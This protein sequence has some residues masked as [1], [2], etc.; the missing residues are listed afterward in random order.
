MTHVSDATIETEVDAPEAPALSAHGMLLWIVSGVV[1]AIAFTVYAL[2]VGSAVAPPLDGMAIWIFFL[3]A[4]G[5]EQVNV[6]LRRRGGIALSPGAVV[7]AL[8]LLYFS[9][10]SLVLVIAAAAWITRITRTPARAAMATASALMQAT[11][12]ATVYTVGRVA[13]PFAYRSILALMLAVVAAHAVRVALGFTLAR[14]IGARRDDDGGVD[15]A[16]PTLLA[17]LGWAVVAL[18]LAFAGEASTR[19][20]VLVGLLVLL[21]TGLTWAYVSERYRRRGLELAQGMARAVLGAAQTESALVTMLERAQATFHCRHAEIVLFPVEADEHPMRTTVGPGGEREVMVP[22]ARAELAQ[23]V[24]DASEQKHGSLITGDAVR[25][26]VRGVTDPEQNIALVAPLHGE[27]RVLGTIALVGSDQTDA[28]LEAADVEL[29]EAL[30]NHVGAALEYGQVERSLAQLGELERKLAHQAYH[31]SLTGL[32]NRTLLLDLLERALLRNDAV[33]GDVVVLYVDLDDFKSIND[34]FGHPAG[35]AVL[36]EVGNRIGKCLRGADT[37]ARLGGDEFAVLIDGAPQLRG[38]I[39]VA[40]RVLRSL[41]PP[42]VHEGR[43]HLV[44]GS[45]GIA[46]STPGSSAEALLR[47]ADI[48]MYRAK[49]AGKGRF[50]IFEESMHA[51]I[52]RQMDMR[53]DLARAIQQDELVLH[54][55]PLVELE[56]ARMVGVEALVRWQHPE[57]GMVPPG[58]FIPLAEETGLI[59]ALGSWVIDKACKQAGEWH[60]RFP[61]DP[62]LS[63]NIN[64]SASQFRT[65]E[66]AEELRVALE[67]N[68]VRPSTVTLEITESVFKEGWGRIL[69]VLEELRDLGVRLAIDDFGTGYSSLTRLQEMP[70]EV[71]KIPK[72]FVDDLA[73][74]SGKAT[75]ARTVVRIGDTIGMKTVAEGIETVEKWHQLRHL[76]C[77]YGQGYLFGKP[78]PASDLEAHFERS[79]AALAKRPRTRPEVRTSIAETA[80]PAPGRD[81]ASR[82]VA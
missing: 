12:A 37:P 1:A 5:A 27:S 50:E 15:T 34:S 19:I 79:M 2:F 49:A 39:S 33:E 32:A 43:E 47:D 16:L 29:L 22:V 30:G 38:V 40:E 48:A 6:H 46:F 35:D 10:G 9:P 81:G 41:A 54:Y 45:V 14:L 70:V 82:L 56:S 59:T 52:R 44:N 28:A 3:I 20:A 8:G 55:Q 4:L 13:D 60:A 24:L 73:G 31:D 64:V 75:L 78:V 51:D 26:V 67:G 80:A 61:F 65:H 11:A 68:G 23:A 25:G 76:G 69:Q 72:P 17:S 57:R 66:L 7:L 71:L 58:D 36:I 63:M 77:D 53:T 42:I 21:S 74:V 18:V 62:A